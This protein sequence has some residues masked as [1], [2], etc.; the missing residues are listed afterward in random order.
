MIST[1]IKIFYAASILALF[2]FL[3]IATNSATMGDLPGKVK[4]YFGMFAIVVIVMTAGYSTFAPFCNEREKYGGK[5]GKG[6][7]KGCG[8]T[9][10][11]KCQI[12][13]KFCRGGPYTWQG[14]STRA[15][16]C[17]ALAATK[18]GAQRLI[19]TNVVL[20]SLECLVV[21]SNLHP[22]RMDAGRMKC[23]IH[24]LAAT[25]KTTESFKNTHFIY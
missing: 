22:C 16:K 12:D 25:W 9:G 11:C 2:V 18:A 5:G 4:F 17:R 13:P 19:V 3:Y 15:K 7:C 21:D 10:G 23:A 24:Q 14:N 6:A 20:G 1:V 8:N